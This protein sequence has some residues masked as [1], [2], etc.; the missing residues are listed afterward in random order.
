M[1]LNPAP[2]RRKSAPKRNQPAQP[3]TAVEQARALIPGQGPYL[4]ASLSNYPNR[5]WPSPQPGKLKDLVLHPWQPVVLDHA[6]LES[7]ALVDDFQAGKVKLEFSTVIPRRGEPQLSED[8]TANMSADEKGFCRE[9]CRMP[10]S[11]QFVDALTL[12][13]TLSENGL[14]GPSTGRVTRSYLKL[15]HR[16]LLVAI[17]ELERRFQK[18]DDLLQ[19]LAD[20]IAKI[21]SLG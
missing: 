7:T 1:A 15:Q 12:A 3:L 2:T 16:Q 19:L 11:K 6:W 9:V 4:V 14:P 17:Q 13:D 20:Q 21:D 5:A 18:R 8:L 10:L